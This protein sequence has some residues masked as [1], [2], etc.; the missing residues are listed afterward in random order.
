MLARNPKWILAALGAGALLWT[1]GCAASGEKAVRI[2]ESTYQR[3]GEG[4]PSDETAIP[5]LGESASLEEILAL[6][7]ARNPGLRAAFDRWTAAHEQI[8]QARSLPDPKVSYAYFIESVETRVGPQRQKFGFS[9]TIPLFGK[10]GLRGAVATQAANAASA[11]FEAVRRDLRFRVTEQWNDYY[12]LSRAIAVTDENVQLLKNLESVALSQYIAGRA[13]HSS[14]VRAQVELGRLEDR[15]RTLRDQRAPILASLNAELDLPYGSAIAWPESIDTSPI[16]L[17]E[18]ELRELLLKESPRLL[19]LSYTKERE[20]AASRLAERN[21]L[22]DLTIGAEYID[23]GEAR[24]PNVPDS[25]KNAA[26]ASAMINIPLWYGRYSA[27]KSQAK[28]R[29]SATEAEYTQL[30]NRLLADLERIQFELRDAERRVD[31]YAYTLLPKARE[32]FEVTE[33]GFTTGEAGFLDLVDSQRILLEF[34][35][36]YERALADR[37][38]RRAQIEQIVGIDFDGDE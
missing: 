23:T 16:R 33:Q 28:A 3:P 32:S 30:R 19:A 29:L 35:L 21:P 36:A 1:T 6:A 25:G 17:S 12:Y 9:Q 22:P 20:A 8:P 15:L 27:E 13:S 24:M 11:H 5:G 14:V 37:A 10:L 2:Q 18:A 38:T 34:G 7:E 26:V 31:L 4:T